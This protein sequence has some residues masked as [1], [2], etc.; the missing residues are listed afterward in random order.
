MMSLSLSYIRNEKAAIT[1][2]DCLQNVLILAVGDDAIP[3]FDQ[4]PEAIFQIHPRCKTV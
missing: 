3:V 1:D 4:S 2:K